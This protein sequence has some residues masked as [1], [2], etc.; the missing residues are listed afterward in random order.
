ME[1]EPVIIWVRVQPN[2]SQNAVL[3]FKDGVLQIRIAAPPI[4]GEANQELIKYLSRILGIS[5]RQLTI[6][7]GMTNKR[8]A[9]G[10]SGLTPNQVKER[11]D[12]TP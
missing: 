1:K 8:K 12:C 11:L 7:K 6:E 3:G 4:K 9:I 10:I 2:A 5:K